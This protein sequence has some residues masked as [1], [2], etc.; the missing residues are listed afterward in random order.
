MANPKT[1]SPRVALTRKQIEEGIG[2]ELLSLCEGISGDGT[3]TKEDLT[4]LSVWLKA[5]KEETLPSVVYL[6]TVFRRV[7][8]DGKVTRE[9]QKELLEAIE[10]IL[11]PEQ[12]RDAKAARKAAETKRREEQKAE[13]IRKMAAEEAEERRRTPE[14]SFDFMVAGVAHEGRHRLVERCLRVGDRVLLRP[15]PNNRYDQFAV[16]V[17]LADGREFG[18]VPRFDSEDVHNCIAE[19]GYYIASIKKI[20]EGRAFPTPVVIL[21]FYRQ[22]QLAQIAMMGPI[23]C[24]ALGGPEVR[25]GRGTGGLKRRKRWWEFWK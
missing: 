20:L 3:I 21:D 19:G 8:A 9:E 14:A 15:D 23:P 11:P 16:H 7:V 18:Y 6:H 22:D 2:A 5:N 12:R 1:T 4:A 25:G 17:T 10:R 24:P 13:Q